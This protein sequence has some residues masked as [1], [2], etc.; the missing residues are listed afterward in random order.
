MDIHK[1]KSCSRDF[2]RVGGKMSHDET[3]KPV[4]PIFTVELFPD[5]S[6]ELL[7]V[8]KGLPPSA[9]ELPTVCAGW[10]VKDVAAHLLG[11]TLS[12]LSFGR[13]QLTHPKLGVTKLDFDALVQAIGIENAEWIS[14]ARRFSYPLLVDF[15]ELTDPQ[16]YEYFRALP[17]FESNG[18]A[19][20]WAGDY[21]SPN[22]FDIAREYT[23]KWLHQQH[24]RQAVGRPLL[25][26]RKWLFPVLDTFL[27]ALPYTYRN[28]VAEQ[29]TAIV[30]R[31]IGEAGGD[32]SLRR[33]QADWHLYTGQASA[34]VARVSLDQETT[35]RLFTKGI[36]PEEA[37]LGIHLEGDPLLGKIIL[38][39][40]SI[41]A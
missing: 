7:G 35:W 1:G 40:V 13:D 25:T 29:G 9:W 19:V 26:E 11:G 31:I 21:Q 8:L 33:E 27:R 4:E 14:I 24:I 18:P 20:A 3:M 39:I 12:R 10:T 22:W 23:E 15:L 36:T 41:M 34:P 17:P 16:L 6:A 2:H 32:W 37:Q 38:Q 5:L 30:F 28:Q